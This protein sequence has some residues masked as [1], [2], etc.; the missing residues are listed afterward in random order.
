MKKILA[1]IVMAAFCLTGT[2]KTADEV[3]KE[4]EKATGAQVIR[5]NQEMIAMQMGEKK[6]G[7]KDVDE[8]LKLIDN[9]SVLIID[10][11]DKAKTDIF[12]SKTEE[13]D[14]TFYESIATVFDNDDRVKV[15][16]HM[17]GETIKE[18]V[19]AVT[20]GE[21]CVMVHLT[22]SIPKDKIGQL[23]NDKTINF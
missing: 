17:E 4:I 2:A 1:F 20:D 22:G 5:F 13:L 16:G 8:M 19:V 6:T 3:I 18:I 21:D 11:T 23:I 9:G 10:N 7:I 12:N 15:L 14:D